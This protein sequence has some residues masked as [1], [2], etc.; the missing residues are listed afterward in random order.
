MNNRKAALIDKLVRAAAKDSSS[1]GFLGKR[2]M[3]RLPVSREYSLIQQV[4]LG[5][6]PRPAYAYAAICASETAVRL[7]YKEVTWIEFGVAGG[8]GLIVLEAIKAQVERV[9]PI[10][11]RIIGFDMGS[12]LPTPVDYRDLPYAWKSG[13]YEM[14]IPAL[15]S[16]LT[17]AELNIGPISDTLP[18]FIANGSPDAPIGMISF[19]L[20]YYSSTVEAF[21]IFDLSADSILPRVFC[22]MDDVIGSGEVFSDYT[23]ARLAIR[24]FNALSELRK[25]SACHDF[26]QFGYERWQEKVM[27]YHDFE[28]PRYSDYVGD[29]AGGQLPI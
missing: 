14:D 6:L 21:K 18:T 27:V 3:A 24:E 23:G 20:D 25:L 22:N 12:G 19:D 15:K 9:L 16:R 5:I 10:H 1:V 4:Q 11:I 17:N 28:H 7:G 29:D 13:F 2:L 8:A 26:A